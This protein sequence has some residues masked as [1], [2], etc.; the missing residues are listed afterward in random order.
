M[1]EELLALTSGEQ[2]GGGGV[3]LLGAGCLGY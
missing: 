1:L 2:W 3:G